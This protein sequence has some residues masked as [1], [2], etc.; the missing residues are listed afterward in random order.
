MSEKKKFISITQFEN[1]LSEKIVLLFFFLEVK[2]FSSTISG[3]E[4]ILCV[5]S[6]VIVFVGGKLFN[7][8]Y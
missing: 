2:G 8:I 7:I 3:K 4:R 1:K 5:E 6:F